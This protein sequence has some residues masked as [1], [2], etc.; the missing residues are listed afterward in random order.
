M[1][2]N[3]S[4]YKIGR[5]QDRKYRSD[6]DDSDDTA[7][8][9]APSIVQIKCLIFLTTLKGRLLSPFYR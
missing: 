8:T 1:K 5:R 9:Y 4:L 3:F 6:D 2:S 7:L